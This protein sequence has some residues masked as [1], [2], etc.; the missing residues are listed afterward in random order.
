MRSTVIITII[1]TTN[2]II[3]IIIIAIIIV[4]AAPGL[5][6]PLRGPGQ[7]CEAGVQRWYAR[8]GRQLRKQ[9]QGGAH[10]RAIQDLA[11]SLGKGQEPLRRPR[12]HQL[13]LHVR[14]HRP[15]GGPGG[16]GAADGAGPPKAAGP[17]RHAERLG[18]GLMGSTL[19]GSLQ[20]YC[21]MPDLNK[22]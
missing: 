20:K 13:A 1:I 2:I 4:L 7:G 21:F 3:F 12:P 22:Y 18:C 5:R 16:A 8:A 10:V 6:L 11:V 17:R 14:G 19:M 15:R 9:L